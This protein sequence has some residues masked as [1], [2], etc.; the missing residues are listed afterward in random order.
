MLGNLRRT[1]GDLL[2]S[3]GKGGLAATGELDNM[4]VIV[5]VGRTAVDEMR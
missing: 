3:V 1:Y 2:L 5:F 4:E